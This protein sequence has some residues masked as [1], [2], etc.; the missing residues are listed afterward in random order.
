MVT[1]WFPTHDEPES[2][3]FV[4]RDARAVSRAHDVRVI[5]VDASRDARSRA[6]S[7]T[8][9]GVAVT[10]VPLRRWNPVD[11]AVVRREV[12]R[13]A[14]LSDVVHTHALTGLVPFAAARGWPR[15]KWVHTEH[16]SGVTAPGTLTSFQRLARRLLLPLLA[17]PAVVIVACDRL[18]RA[19]A[20]SRRGRIAHVPC[21]VESPAALV[22][23]PRE[24]GLVRLIGVGG[25]VPRKGPLVALSTVHELRR[26]GVP[27][28][29]TWVGDG[30][31]RGEML[32]AAS[33]M[34]LTAELTLTGS[35]TE[36]G[37]RQQLDAH[38]MLLLPTLGD[39]FC[40]AAAEA[41][42]HGRPIV[43]GADTGARDYSS[44]EVS[45][46]VDDALNPHA[47]AD[48][49]TDLYEKTRDLTASD[50]EETVRGRFTA[51]RVSELL[52]AV[53]ESVAGPDSRAQHERDA[54]GDE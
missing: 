45:R 46:F 27:A 29:I 43:S 20:R 31:Q 32:D 48:A 16:W 7:S 17:K 35:L 36:A 22:P 53:Y 14:S 37:V 24:E 19:I 51:A 40:I 33:R 42:V 34:G 23:A 18:A 10:R 9:D 2:G 5:H 4:L 12:R 44:P 26:R 41:L 1:P 15:T 11:W 50:I 30:P 49:V 52:S 38:D 28:S 8:V 21:V 25:I 3:I 54:H 6:G 39:N 13:A 47:Y